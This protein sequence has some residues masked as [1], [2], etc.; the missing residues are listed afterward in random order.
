MI[1]PPT[2]EPS[3]EKKALDKFNNVA[4]N[5]Q[6]LMQF[7]RIAVDTFER[8][9]TMKLTLHVKDGAAKGGDGNFSF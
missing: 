8:K 4:Y 5:N 2:K 3:E 9:G 7:I 1:F 6:H